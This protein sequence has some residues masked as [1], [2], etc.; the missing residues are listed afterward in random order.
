M[1]T[2]AIVLCSAAVLCVATAVSGFALDGVALLAIGAASVFVA[3]FASDYSRVPTYNLAPVP[4]R[5]K[6]AARRSEAGV[7][8]ATIASF[9][10]MVG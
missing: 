3:M 4:A 6:V 9:N 1:K 7:E 5:R 8:F 10:S 2:L